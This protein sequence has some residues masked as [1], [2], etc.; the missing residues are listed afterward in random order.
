MDLYMHVSVMCG[1]W[2]YRIHVQLD[3]TFYFVHESL[4]CDLYHPCKQR[5]AKKKYFLRNCSVLFVSLK[6][7]NEGSGV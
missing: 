7:S 5:H 3:Y 2:E 4:R 6:V 1:C